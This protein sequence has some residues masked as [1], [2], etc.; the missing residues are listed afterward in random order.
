[1]AESILCPKC[2]RQNAL[3][4][5]FCGEC[6][7]SLKGAAW[8]PPE[9]E[10]VGFVHGGVWQRPATEFLRRVR[11]EEMSSQLGRQQLE[12]PRGS[13]AVLVRDGKIDEVLSPG[14]QTAVGWLDRVVNLFNDKVA[15]TEFYLLDVRPLPIPFQVDARSATGEALTRLQVLVEL[16]LRRDDHGGLLSFLDRFATGD[17]VS[18][19]TLYDALRP[20]VESAI[21][22][23]LASL[24]SAS[25]DLRAVEAAMADELRRSSLGAIGMELSVRITALSSSVSVDLSLGGAPAPA[26]K[27]C[28]S[29]RVELPST[30]KFCK[31]CGAQQPIQGSPNRTCA[32]CSH[33][34]PPNKKF[35]TKCGATFVERAPESEGLFTKDGQQVELDVVLRAEGDRAAA[36]KDRIGPK[37]ASAAAKHLRRFDFAAL[38]TAEGFAALEK[39]ILEDVHEAL[40]TLGLSVTDISVLDL[41]SK[42][43]QWL[44]EG[45]AEL[46]QARNEIALGRD[47]LAVEEQNLELQTLGFDLALRNQRAE[48]DH[49]F[50]QRQDE[51]AERRRQQ[52]L[53]DEHASLDVADA[54]REAQR[55]VGLDAAGRTRDRAIAAEDQ[56]DALTDGQRAQERTRQQ[57]GFDRENETAAAEHEMSMERKVADHDA[58]LS[59]Q[60]AQLG[61]EKS[62][63]D[64]DDRAYAARSGIDTDAYA[65][66]TRGQADVEV[67]RSKQDLELDGEAR[68]RAM[69]RD[70]QQQQL[71]MLAKMNEME[72]AEQREKAEQERLAAKQ[73]Q[74]H[75]LAMREQLKG[76]STDQMLAM[77]ASGQGG[78]A[79]AAALAEKFKADAAGGAAMTSMQKEM[80]ERML[81][82]RS[83]ASQQ[84][85]AQ[86]A[87]MQ[88]QMMQMF[89]MMQAQSAQQMQVMGNVATAAVGGQRES[90]A[91]RQAA[92]A[93]GA[94]GSVHMAERAMDGM[95]RVAAASAGAPHVAMPAAPRPPE[96]PPEAPKAAPKA[97]PKCGG[98]GAAMEPG[99]KFCGECGWRP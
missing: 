11:P 67:A 69:R 14:K 55:A 8:A 60:A 66:R 35:C 49:Q 26:K 81:A 41:R 62:R 36:T 93:S 10:D 6:G 50:H 47:W 28:V 53:E 87:A 90:E 59:R 71:E 31:A 97:A 4:K 24:A 65:V 34:V 23:H 21:A 73:E 68:R 78:E 74:D 40:R 98:C 70:D 95:A 29:C 16:R 91:A 72:R 86:Q 1:M 27:S 92:V 58:A 99:D 52:G 54:R 20:S 48:R 77:Q 33:E 82:E 57:A 32:A 17:S 56:A 19:R 39:A 43:G 79:I 45:R 22:P 75:A 88:A 63:L 64:T 37:V 30:T 2:G 15:R 12:V 76:L 51:L 9:Q 3:G 83:A 13:V 18:Q 25:G 84:T 80:Y 42:G 85:L 61:S 7:E 38:A 46:E 94:Q 44:L 5:K 89:Q 96:P